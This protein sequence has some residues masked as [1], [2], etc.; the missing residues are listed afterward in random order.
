MGE[1]VKDKNTE[2]AEGVTKSDFRSVN[3][4]P[5]Q[6]AYLEIVW[7]SV[8]SVRVAPIPHAHFPFPFL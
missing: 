7:L 3:R 4:W 5:F 2:H 8:L 1:F 6:T